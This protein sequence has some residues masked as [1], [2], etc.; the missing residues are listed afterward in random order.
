MPGGEKLN[1][2]PVRSGGI[3]DILD[4]MLPAVRDWS[5]WSLF[6]RNVHR[7]AFVA[8]ASIFVLLCVDAF[9]ASDDDAGRRTEL[10]IA[11]DE[12]G[13]RGDPVFRE[14]NQAG[15]VIAGIGLLGG[16]AVLGVVI[17]SKPA[18]QRAAAKEGEA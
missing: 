17:G 10:P 15:L 12:G 1:G 14:S 18:R 11:A 8:F 6:A 5:T 4:N 13:Q 16:W 3:G 9:V 2:P 7:I